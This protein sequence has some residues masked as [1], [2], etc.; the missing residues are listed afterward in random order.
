[1]CASDRLQESAP[2][3]EEREAKCGSSRAAQPF[4]GRHPETVPDQCLLDALF[5]SRRQNKGHTSATQVLAWLIYQF[6]V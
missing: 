4:G 1:M 3:E 6:I 5:T 2:Q